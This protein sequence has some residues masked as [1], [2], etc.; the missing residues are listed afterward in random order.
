MSN[1][2]NKE[3]LKGLINGPTP[4]AE[5]LFEVLGTRAYAV[6][7]GRHQG[8]VSVRCAD[9]PYT[10]LLPESDW[11]RYQELCKRWQASPKDEAGA[12]VAPRRI[13]REDLACIHDALERELGELARMV[14]AAGTTLDQVDAEDALALVLRRLQQAQ[15]ALTDLRGVAITTGKEAADDSL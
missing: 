5:R 1:A 15:K 4:T 13:S 2:I 6:V 12:R 8:M 7:C 10:L 11:R 14:A 9:L 3:H